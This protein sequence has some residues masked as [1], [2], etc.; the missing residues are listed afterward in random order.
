M[1]R[2]GDGKGAHGCTRGKGGGGWGER[3]WLGEEE[4]IIWKQLSGKDGGIGRV[5]KGKGGGCMAR[6]RCSNDK[7]LTRH[8]LIY[9]LG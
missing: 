2:Y 9:Y 3:G 5:M 7:H 6:R 4:A 1:G 8:Q